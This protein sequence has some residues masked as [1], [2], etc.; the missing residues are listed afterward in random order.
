NTLG[1]PIRFGERILGAIVVETASRADG[2]LVM[3]L[4]SCGLFAGARLNRDA[5]LQSTARYE[6]LAFTDGLTGVANRRRFDEVLAAEWK[7]A[8][9]E[10]RPITLLMMD[11]DYFKLFNDN[12]GHQAGD[13]CLQQVARALHEGLRRPS[14]LFARYGGEEFVALLPDTELRGATVVG[15]Q[16]LK[17][18][19]ALGIAHAGSSL[20]RVS[21]SIGAATVAPSPDTTADILLRAADTALYE[22]K[23]AGRNRVFAPDYASPAAAVHRS[24]AGAPNNL[25]LQFTRLVGRAEEVVEVK[26]LLATSPLVTI[27]GIGG[28]GKTRIALQVAADLV[29]DYA[30]GTWFVDL[31]PLVDATLIPA[32]IGALLSVQVPSD[33]GAVSA[34]VRVLEDRQVLLILDNCEHLLA[35]VHDLVE[36][37]VA[38]CP[39][40]RI[41][42]TS[43]APLEASGEAV[44]RLPLLSLPPPGTE[45]TAARALTFDAVALF[46]ERAKAAKRTFAVTDENAALIVDVC[47]QLDGIA[48]AIELAAARLSVI[49]VAQLAERLTH[50]LRILTGGDRTAPARRQT[51]RALIDWS[52]E[53][54]VKRERLVFIRLAIFAGGCTLEA[55]RE[56]CAGEGVDADEMGDLISGLVTKSMLVAD[57][58]DGKS[59]YRLLESMHE[60]AREKLAESGAET[61]LARKH[62]LYLLRIAQQSAGRQITTREWYFS[63]R[64]ELENFRAAL[65]WTL[66]AGADVALGAQ[67]VAAL[68]PFFDQSSSTE[69][70]RW[71]QVALERL[72]PGANAPI[73]ARLWFGLAKSTMTLPAPQ[74]RA[75]AERAVGLYRKLDDGLG[76]ARALRVLAGILAW[77]FPEELELADATLAESI[78]LARA[79]DNP[80]EVSFSLQTRCDINEEWDTAKKRAIIEEGLV[81]CRAYGND[82]QISG[83]FTR[84]S[85]LEFEAGEYARALSYGRDAMR[86]A[87]AAGATETFQVAASNFVHYAAATNNWATTHETA[88]SLIRTS[89]ETGS[90]EGL[91]W[92]VQALAAVSANIGDYARAARLLGF[93]G[94]RVGVLHGP[95]LVGSSQAIVH[96]DILQILHAN[97][98]PQELHDQLEIGEG[99]SDGEAVREALEL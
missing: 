71:L 76:L 31:S 25:P 99:F 60:Y 75:A 67:L 22:A 88:E 54:L 35:P 18:V 51:M 8:T 77:F 39:K 30:D 55:A 7:R 53:L 17:R 49:G 91:T 94:K 52:Y 95:M 43:R 98:T 21:M 15:E 85:E 82:R 29:G 80:L 9:H 40:L 37:L 20:G 96:R 89:R 65:Q 1:V 64:A 90:A 56:V 84:L 58:A 62:A 27:S 42:A 26:K 83:E 19:A 70:L 92:S 23:R 14:D 68:E 3:L 59:R 45:I 41:L 12:Y 48:L 73:E 28:S 78:E 10:R 97:L 32:T 93:C 5:L 2:E 69:G 47:H 74:M 63:R 72:P 87:E 79:T 6:Q 38:A 61:Q 34:L 4:E 50:R 11:L 16:L 36:A 66:I 81:L 86:F 46:A 57:V 13:L 24:D 33:D 44:Y